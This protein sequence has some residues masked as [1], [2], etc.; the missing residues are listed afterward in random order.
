MHATLHSQTSFRACFA[1]MIVML[2]MWS[3]SA[4]A[5]EKEKRSKAEIEKAQYSDLMVLSQTLKTYKA[6]N[7]PVSKA[8]DEIWIQAT[9]KPPQLI[10]SAWFSSKNNPE[11][12]ISLDLTYAYAYVNSLTDKGAKLLGLKPGIS[13]AEAIKRLRHFGV[14]FDASLCPAVVHNAKEGTIAVLV[15]LGRSGVS[16]SP[17]WRYLPIAVRSSHTPLEPAPL[18]PTSLS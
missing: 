17:A 16:I 11:P 12:L 9:G 10:G 18:R 8:L 3:A 5:Q 1:G 13:S 15:P 6:E 7:L 2:M 4:H 14:D